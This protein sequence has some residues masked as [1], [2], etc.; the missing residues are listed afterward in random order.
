[1]HR[2][3]NGEEAARGAKNA[4]AELQALIDVLHNLPEG[5]LPERES[6]ERTRRK[7]EQ[8]LRSVVAD[9]E[10]ELDRLGRSPT[11]WRATTA[12]L[13]DTIPHF[14]HGSTADLLLGPQAPWA[15]RGALFPTRELHAFTAIKRQAKRCRQCQTAIKGHAGAAFIGHAMIVQAEKHH[16]ALFRR[17]LKELN[18]AFPVLIQEMPAWAAAYR[19]ATAHAALEHLDSPIATFAA[20]AYLEQ[21]RVL[22]W[23]KR[24]LLPKADRQAQRRF[25]A[26]IEGG[27]YPKLAHDV[28]RR[29]RSKVAREQRAAERQALQPVW[30][31]VHSEYERIRQ[32]G[33]SATE[34]VKR[35]RTAGESQ[36]RIREV[37]A[38]TREP[39]PWRGDFYSERAIWRIIKAYSG[40]AAIG[41]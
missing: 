23:V 18:A 14:G 39:K 34:A 30:E 35:L 29:E 2:N 32:Q 27:K 6:R 24:T 16:K 21:Q 22:A 33:C 17:Y 3:P 19:A 20:A 26:S 28:L 15:G 12:Y 10:T 7:L 13:T 37:V 11:A 38:K 5:Q 4:K 8:H 31:A 1:M 40:G 41:T 9:A 25:L 36:Q